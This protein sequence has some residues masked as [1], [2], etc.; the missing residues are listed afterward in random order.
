MIA[1]HCRMTFTIPIKILFVLTTSNEIN[2][3]DLSSFELRRVKHVLH[4]RSALQKSS[5]MWQFPWTLSRTLT[6][7]R[8]CAKWHSHVAAD[9]ERISGTCL[10]LDVIK[11]FK[12]EWK[13][14]I[15]SLTKRLNSRF[16]SLSHEISTRS[17][18]I[19]DALIID[20]DRFRVASCAFFEA[21]HPRS[22]EKS[23]EY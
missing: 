4:F 11:V 12:T 8:I 5:L 16:V 22:R 21:K 6:A 20:D 23:F 9:G 14:A 15:F 3:L 7:R 13:I 19:C 2:L 18:C 17:N 10:P 1:T